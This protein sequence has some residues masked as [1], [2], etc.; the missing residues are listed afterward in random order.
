MKRAYKRTN[1]IA[2]TQQIAHIHRRERLLQAALDGMRQPRTST[3]VKEPKTVKSIDDHHYISSSRNCSIRLS[4]W[5]AP[6]NGDVRYE[7]LLDTFF[8][9]LDILIYFYRTS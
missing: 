3:P 5:L 8:T 4:P 2:A 7:V 9:A 6:L 1:K